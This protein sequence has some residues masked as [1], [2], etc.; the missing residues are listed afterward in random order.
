M[1]SIAAG[2]VAEMAGMPVIDA[3]EHLPPEQ[4]L[5][6]QRADV[7]TRLYAHYSLT[8]VETAGLPGAREALKD[9][10]RPLEERWALFRPFLSAV[11]DTGYARAAQI[12]ARDLF[13]VD[14]IN[15]GTYADLSERIQAANT[16]GLY[17]RIL[18]DRCGIERVLNQGTWDDGPRGYA[19]R[20]HR[21]F[22]DFRWDVAGDLCGVYRRWK[23]RNGGDFEDLDAWLDF[24]LR[25]VVRDGCVGLKYGANL[26]TDLPARQESDGLFRKVRDGSITDREAARFSAWLNLKSIEKAPEHD[27]VAA[28]H[29]G[30]NW[31]CWQDFA[32]KNPMNVVP[33]L[34]R[35]RRTQF[36]LYHGGIPWVREMAV[37]GNQY[38]N[39]HL[40]LVWC[41]QI[42]PYMTENVLNEWLDLVPANKI[43]GFGGDYSCGPEKT[44]GALVMARENMARALAVRVARGQMSESRAVDVCRAWLYENPR[45]IY[46]LDRR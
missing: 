4:D 37:I 15:D 11:R 18:G 36:D 35:Y 10:A 19:V 26:P 45:R 3:H 22:M 29:C 8:N 30:L 44:Y 32:A 39:A 21:G 42:S 9:T 33:L 1:E 12:A 40:N 28:V 7:F 41:H 2:L 31:C 27:L 6:S 38:P 43:I 46:A 17:Q 14:D 24:W 25:Q 16:P 23:E 13:G 20:V 34:M 5:T